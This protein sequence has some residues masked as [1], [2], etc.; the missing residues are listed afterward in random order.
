MKEMYVFVL[1]R[2]CT[3][4]VGVDG[5]YGWR[6]GVQDLSH[7]HTVVASNTYVLVWPV[8]ARSCVD[9]HSFV[10]PYM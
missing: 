3:E 2:S 4:V 7:N 1:D 10:V 9:M 5:W 8:K 6:I